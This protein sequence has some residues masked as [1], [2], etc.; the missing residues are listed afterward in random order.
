MFS[1]P[2][3]SLG[4]DISTKA[5]KTKVRKMRQDF[6]NTKNEP[7]AMGFPVSMWMID[8]FFTPYLHLLLE[9]KL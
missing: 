2:A 7:I 5:G 9:V 1:T 3:T 6:G 4:I 8:A